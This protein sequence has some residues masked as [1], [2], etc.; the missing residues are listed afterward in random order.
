MRKIGLLVLAII[1][2]ALTTKA[3][4]YNFW[5]NS[6]SIAEQLGR[7]GGMSFSEILS[8]CPGYDMY[9]YDFGTT[10]S[11]ECGDE[12][13]GFYIA[14]A[15]DASKEK[16]PA[17]NDFGKMPVGTDEFIDVTNYIHL[18][19]NG[20]IEIY[21]QF[22][23]G[24]SFNRAYLK[25]IEGEHYEIRFV[26]EDASSDVAGLETFSF[27][28]WHGEVI[29][30]LR[31]TN[32]GK[33][34]F[35]FSHI[36]DGK[37]YY[38]L[39]ILR[40]VEIKYVIQ[41]AMYINGDATT[42]LMFDARETD[43]FM[44]IAKSD[45]FKNSRIKVG[46]QFSAMYIEV[47]LDETNPDKRYR[48]YLSSDGTINESAAS[49]APMNTNSYSLIL[50][51]GNVYDALKGTQTG[52]IAVPFTKHNESDNIYII[53][54][55]KNISTADLAENFSLMVNDGY[56]DAMFN[57]TATDTYVN[58]SAG[59][60][61]TFAQNLS[62]N[63]ILL[64]VSGENFDVYD[65]YLVNEA[66]PADYAKA[67][68]H[69]LPALK[70]WTNGDADAAIRNN[71]SGGFLDIPQNIERGD[72][73]TSTDGVIYRYFEPVKNSE[74]KD[75]PNL[76]YLDIPEGV[77]L[78]A[79]MMPL[80]ADA[81]ADSR[82]FDVFN[83]VT[84]DGYDAANVF[85]GGQVFY[86]DTWWCANP[87]LHA[88]E[89]AEGNVILREINTIYPDYVVTKGDLYFGETEATTIYGIT[90]FKIVGETYNM[91]V[92]G[93]GIVDGN[94]YYLYFN[95]VP[96]RGYETT[97]PILLNVFDDKLTADHPLAGKDGSE[98]T[99]YTPKGNAAFNI[100]DFGEGSSQVMMN[101]SDRVLSNGDANYSVDLSLWAENDSFEFIDV[102]GTQRWLA[103]AG[104]A[105]R[106]N[107]WS[108]YYSG[109]W[110]DDN[111]TGAIHIDQTGIEYYRAVLATN[112]DQA[113]YQILSNTPSIDVV[114]FN[115]Y[116][117]T[118]EGEGNEDH[119]QNLIYTG[120]ELHTEIV[121]QDGEDLSIT[122]TFTD[123]ENPAVS[124]TE[125][126]TFLAGD[127][128]KYLAD[129]TFAPLDSDDTFTEGNETR[130]RIDLGQWL[131]KPGMS[132]AVTSQF[133]S[134]QPVTVA[135]LSANSLPTPYMLISAVPVGVGSEEETNTTYTADIAW[136]NLVVN[137]YPH[138]YSLYQ[139]DAEADKSI[140]PYV[141]FA[142][143]ESIE[144]AVS[145]GLLQ[146]IEN[147]NGENRHI[148]SSL[149]DVNIT[150]TEF[151]LGH[152]GSESNTLVVTIGYVGTMTYTYAYPTDGPVALASLTDEL[153]YA[154]AAD[155]FTTAT[156]VSY[157][158]ATT[159]DFTMTLKDTVQTGIDNVDGSK[160]KVIAGNGTLTITG[161]EAPVSIYDMT[162]ACVYA[163]TDRTIALDRGIYVVAL[164]TATC[165][166][167]V[168]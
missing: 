12:S 78:N 11:P 2:V 128:E 80:S 85:Q 122:L 6:G 76:Y 19:D 146:N 23:A 156:E 165:K 103:S 147:E 75:I 65:M 139:F 20:N 49:Q 79:D 31:E 141:D 5:L 135:G 28:M 77:T 37:A 125:T 43:K 93:G 52:T 24:V 66:V 48:M 100:P 107:K 114:A 53:N 96:G 4:N 51:K 83:I 127:V 32:N 15:S 35:Q 99:L 137:D 13:L 110:L 41:C 109:T 18:V 14:G 67:Q 162:G 36:T 61:S 82:H 124:Y 159:A 30:A 57:L 42:G 56:A 136:E 50:G 64:R 3:E 95:T 54:L 68:Y 164:D 129:G 84:E 105:L 117:S 113:R 26:N 94:L 72:I 119:S 71:F 38:K 29:E 134:Q 1:A 132:V 152:S 115:Q 73:G 101:L 98:L 112:V 123:P 86:A 167:I 88:G 131:I 39:D 111:N 74:G 47:D 91:Y 163:G 151:G 153:D 33:T 168:R 46:L 89:D 118:A 90:L 138:F 16:F 149:D 102:T 25:V 55:G 144:T 44:P 70:G 155:G 92:D 9:V 130:Y 69:A 45:Y 120:T 121:W 104:D 142:D 126:L 108:N 160:A 63:K 60:K 81:A 150:A 154:V 161:T 166:V 8:Q 158:D 148:G 40:T 143:V 58:A 22:G 59:Q 145:T 157:P 106:A 116:K 87:R 21:F 62:F 140:D 27:N 17:A 10:I 133:G 97:C 34:D 7:S